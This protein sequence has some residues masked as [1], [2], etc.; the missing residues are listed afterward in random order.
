MFERYFLSAVRW[1]DRLA[2]EKVAAMTVHKRNAL[3]L[4]AVAIA[5][6]VGCGKETG[7]KLTG[8]WDY[9]KV[10]TGAEL[11]QF[12]A[13]MGEADDDEGFDVSQVV[14][15]GTATYYDVGTGR[16]DVEKFSMTMK[17]P[18]GSVEV[19]ISMTET[20]RWTLMD[21][22]LTEVVSD[23]EFEPANELTRQ[24]AENDPKAFQEAMD[25]FLTDDT[26]VQT[27]AFEGVNVLKTTE[28]ESGLSLTL[29][30]RATRE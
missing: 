24:F 22:Q 12:V 7:P 4:I 11:E 14:I 13:A 6:F 29:L 5:S 8:T 2:E 26:S 25:V 10:L 16:H 19:A 17:G 21:D 9:E 30:R 28:N 18:E 20:F 27:I 1:I 15:K 23:G 3:L